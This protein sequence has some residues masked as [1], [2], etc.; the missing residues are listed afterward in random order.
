MVSLTLSQTILQKISLSGTLRLWHLP[1][2]IQLNEFQ[3]KIFTS[4]SKEI[5]HGSS[6]TS[7]NNESS[8]MSNSIWKMDISSKDAFIALSIY[9]Y[10]THSIYLTTLK[11]L[12]ESTN[13]QR[14]LTFDSTYGAII[15]YCFSNS[16]LYIL[17]DSH[18]LIKVN[19][20]AVFSSDKTEY[21]Q[22]IKTILANKELELMNEMI[23]KELFKTRGNPAD[24]SYYK[25]K[26]QR[27][28]QQEEKQRKKTS[29]GKS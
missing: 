26:N 3:S 24:S 11:N 5:F 29:S 17:F 8:S 16:D 7:E 23:F 13:E 18:T 1:D 12:V 25:R 27:I 4:S 10:R 28:E 20:I 22:E 9:A 14:K 2:C 21:F 15:D 6:S 19:V